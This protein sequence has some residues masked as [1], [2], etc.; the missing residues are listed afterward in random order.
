MPTVDLPLALP[1]G[2]DVESGIQQQKVLPQP[3][4]QIFQQTVPGGE[5]WLVQS[6]YVGY[7]TDATA[8]TR[9][10]FLNYLYSA[11]NAFTAAMVAGI[12]ASST[13]AISF[14]LGGSAINSTSNPGEGY[15]TAALPWVVLVPGNIIGFEPHGPLANLDAINSQPVITYIQWDLGGSAAGVTLGPFLY[16][17]GPETTGTVTSA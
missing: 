3:G 8:G 12:P 9:G 10:I 16:V 6:V 2:T 13:N 17:P 1:I 5:V 15:F 14:H 4:G 7:N 11:G